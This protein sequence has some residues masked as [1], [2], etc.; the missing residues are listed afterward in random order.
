MQRRN[1]KTKNAVKNEKER[2]TNSEETKETT[3]NRSKKEESANKT[4]M[5]A[6]ESVRDIGEKN[7]KNYCGLF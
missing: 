6:R 4:E 1:L 3:R 5:R 2:E 7:S